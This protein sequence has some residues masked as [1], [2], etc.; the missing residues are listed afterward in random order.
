MS[1][2][3]TSTLGITPN[4][5]DINC[6]KTSDADAKPNGN[7]SHEKRAHGVAKV[8]SFAVRSEIL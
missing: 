1:S 4:I 6:W 7:R 3:D 2:I 5:D 8:S